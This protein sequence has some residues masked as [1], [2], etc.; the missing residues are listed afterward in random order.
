MQAPISRVNLPDIVPKRLNVGCGNNLIDGYIN[1]DSEASLY[2]DIIADIRF[3]LP[4]DD[5][6]V[7][8]ILF[9][10]TVEHIEERYHAQIFREFHRVLEPNGTILVSY[11]EFR[12]CAQNWIDNV[13]G[14]RE[15]WKHTIYGLQRYQSDY[16]VTL[17]DSDEFSEKL[18]E[19]GFKDI[20]YAAENIE[21]Y[22]TVLLAHKGSPAKNYEDLFVN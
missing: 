17:M 1:I 6:S 10:H 3:G 5:N 7:Q 4:F 21:P 9:F 8:E 15:F 11:P 22:N 12:V 19:W 20:N 13:M 18:Q 2:P 14:M 16:H